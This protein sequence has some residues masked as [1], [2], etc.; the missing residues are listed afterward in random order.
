MN[1]LITSDWN[2]AAINGVATS[3]RDLTY[4]LR[5]RGHEV[6]ILSLSSNGHNRVTNDG[7]EVASLPAGVVYPEARVRVGF[8]HRIYDQIVDWGPDIIHS[9]CEMSTFIMAQHLAR[10]CL[11]PVVHTYHTVYED[12]THYFVPDIIPSTHVADLADKVAK[13]AVSEFSKFVSGKCDAFIAPT[14]KVKE[15]LEKYNCKCPI[16]VIP[17]GIELDKYRKTL[18]D[19]ERNELLN[20]YGIDNNSIIAL[21]LG[22]LGEE[23][24]IEELMT[25]WMKYHPKNS[26][27]IIAGGGPYLDTLLEH[28]KELNSSSQIVF[29]GMIDRED[30]WKYYQLADFFMSASTSETQG[31]TYIEALSSGLPLLCRQDSCLDNVVIPYENGVCFTNEEE[32][33]DGLEFILNL[34]HSEGYNRK[35]IGATAN[36]FSRAYFG[37]AVERLYESILF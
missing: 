9:Q 23:K 11:V 18:S 5:C 1:I 31:L 37:E 13:G 25:M 36:H 19:N 34:I 30:T 22:R 3:I 6:K 17:S 32:F 28:A 20:K 16:E 15:L 2:T 24:N 14:P 21:Y 29:A 10:E 7:W 8:M 33:K 35:E 26:K 4:A 27:L 12:Y